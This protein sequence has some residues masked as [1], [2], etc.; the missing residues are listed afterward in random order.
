MAQLPGRS[1]PGLSLQF[2]Q[3]VTRQRY[4]DDITFQDPV[5]RYKGRDAYIANIQLLN[6]LFD[7]KHTTHSLKAQEP[8]RIHARCEYIAVW[9]GV[10]GPAAI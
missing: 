1:K 6:S 8:N 10:A 4:A 7:I 5:A 9:V 3:A 2:V